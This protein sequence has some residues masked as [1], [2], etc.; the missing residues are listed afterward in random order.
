MAISNIKLADRVLKV[1]ASVTLAIT[2]KAKAMKK[3]GIDV[4]SFGA[5]EPD[6]DTPENIKKAAIDSIN[7]GFTK[8]TP[9]PG[10]PELKQAVADYFKRTLD[11]DYSADQVIIGV[12]G[13]H[14]IY[15][16]MMALLNPGDEVLI[17]AP[18][19]V[20]YPEQAKLADATPVIMKT[21][22]ENGFKVTADELK[23]AI[24]P[25]TRLFILNSPSNPTG[26]VYSRE[27]LQALVPI[28]EEKN[29]M[30]LSD[31]IYDRIVYDGLEHVSIAQ[32]GDKIK[33]LTILANGASKTY[34]MTGWRIGYAAAQI[35]II[36]AMGKIQ[37]QST[38]NPTS[39]A[40]KAALEALTG[41]QDAVQVMLKAF[42]ERRDYIV[43]RLNK[44]DGITCI[45]PEGAFYVF[46]NISG[47]F[48]KT[49]GG[50]KINGSLDFCD[51]LLDSVKV[52]AVPGIGF[53]EDECMR[54]S[55]ATSMDAIK[56]GIDRIEKAVK[57]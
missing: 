48:G 5:G 8:Y 11:L 29:V 30:V 42:T 12:G 14:V 56:E 47:C 35:D 28:L 9:A 17:P 22:E 2:A 52:A 50:K 49:L 37:S 34:S 15:N 45:K 36:K 41:P 21:K 1:E 6:F 4:V 27:E 18:Y 40:Q 51:Y 25:K 13:K 3:E 44:I 53:G 24:T 10:I 31:E 19:W 16:I 54:L 43:D 20:S 23:A 46:P 39:I 55:Y 38:S 26:M 7:A 32:L 57:G 33:E